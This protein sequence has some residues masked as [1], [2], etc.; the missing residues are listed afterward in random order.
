MSNGLVA[1]IEM[2]LNIHEKELKRYMTK[3]ESGGWRSGL[4]KRVGWALER[5]T[6]EMNNRPRDEA[7]ACNVGGFL[8]HLTGHRGSPQILER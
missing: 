7:R 6:H 8:D 4:R 3:E 5:D 2:L 1:I